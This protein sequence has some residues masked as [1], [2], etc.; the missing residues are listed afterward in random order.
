MRLA[1]MNVIKTQTQF[2]IC[3]RTATKENQE[4]TM[5]T[6]QEAEAFKWTTGIHGHKPE[7]R[8]IQA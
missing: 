1:I 3:I 8:R 6:Y 5:F 4:T 2:F 7:V